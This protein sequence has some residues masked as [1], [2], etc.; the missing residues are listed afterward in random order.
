M[1]RDEANEE[2]SATGIPA[3]NLAIVA[4]AGNKH[5]EQVS[6][7]ERKKAETLQRIKDAALALFLTKG[8]DDATT[9]EIAKIAG[10]ALGTIFNYA[11]NKRDLLFLICNDELEATVI[12]AEQG[13][14]PALSFLDNVLSIAEY[15][16]IHFARRPEISRYALREMY[17]YSTGKQVGRFKK[18]RDN[19][20]TLFH[21]V[22]ESNLASGAIAS[23]DNAQTVTSI[24]YA[25][26]QTEVRT[27]LGHSKPDPDA[28]KIRF[29][30]Q[31]RI[32][33]NG[34]NPKSEVFELRRHRQK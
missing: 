14:D 17:F 29:A 23:T 30:Q 33:L 31:I 3:D 8:F 34:L 9:R 7:R 18:S 22:V 12:E 27:Y 6:K 26:Y 2:V 19:L 24:I 32:V 21:R 28:A 11:E 25:L 1:S 15:H 16:F 4:G 10:V 5:T 20:I 13:I